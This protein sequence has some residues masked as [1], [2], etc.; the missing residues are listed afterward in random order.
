[1]P[2]HV[3][4]I[5]QVAGSSEKSIEDAIQ[6]GIGRASRT[7]RHGV[8]LLLSPGRDLGRLRRAGRD[9]FALNWHLEFAIPMAVGTIGGMISLLLALAVS[10]ET[11]GKELVAHSVLA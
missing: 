8:R 4:R 1:M 2:D 6:N 11:H 5:I 10:P 3:Y 7:L 9:L